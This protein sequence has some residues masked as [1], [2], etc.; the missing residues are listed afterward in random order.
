MNATLD[1]IEKNKERL[2]RNAGEYDGR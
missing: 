2:D 1:V